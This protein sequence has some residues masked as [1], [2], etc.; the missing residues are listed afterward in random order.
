MVKRKAG[1]LKVPLAEELSLTVDV[2]KQKLATCGD[3]RK[4]LEAVCTHQLLNVRGQQLQASLLAKTLALA[5][6]STDLTLPPVQ[7]WDPGKDL[8]GALLALP[9]LSRWPR[10]GERLELPCQVC[11]EF[12][13]QLANVHSAHSRSRDGAARSCCTI[14]AGC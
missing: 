2:K 4:H 8:Q 14:C 10:R 9:A 11:A 7:R 5:L 3:L 12:K 1:V 13:M 6:R